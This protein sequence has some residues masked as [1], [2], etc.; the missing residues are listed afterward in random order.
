MKEV[1]FLE[2]FAFLSVSKGF[3]IKKA[4]VYHAV[5]NV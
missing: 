5:Q 1:I 2:V 3:T 4:V